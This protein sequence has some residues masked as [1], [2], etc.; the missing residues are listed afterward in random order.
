VVQG[1]GKERSVSRSEVG[2]F[3]VVGEDGFPEIGGEVC[4]CVGK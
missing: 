4:K 1:E 3:V 2:G